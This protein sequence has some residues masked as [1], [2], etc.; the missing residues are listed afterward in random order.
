MYASIYLDGEAEEKEIVAAIN[1]VLRE[2]AAYRTHPTVTGAVEVDVLHNDEADKRRIAFPD[3]FL[4]FRY[5]LEVE[6]GDAAE[7]EGHE[8]VAAILEMAWRRGWAAVASC[9]FEDDLP[10]RGGY[11]CQDIPWPSE[12]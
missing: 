4:H 8:I 12:G 7:S 2:R 5:K 11:K 10:R 1:V 9:D 3:G 6:C